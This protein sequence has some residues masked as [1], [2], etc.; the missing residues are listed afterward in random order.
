MLLQSIASS[1]NGLKSGIDAVQAVVK[2]QGTR[3]TEAENR[4]AVLEDKD[5]GRELAVAL[6]V[7]KFVQTFLEETLNTEIGPGFETAHRTGPQGYR[8][9]HV[10]VR[11]PRFEAREA[12][13]P[14]AREKDHVE[15]RGKRVSFFQD[16]SQ[17][18]IQKHK[19]F[20]E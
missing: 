12:V 17:D 5:L 4:I 15:G 7:Q 11:I 19:T 9:G 3:V 10:Q 16:L 14:G 18:I 6:R 1:I 8:D 20:E 13:L 2:K